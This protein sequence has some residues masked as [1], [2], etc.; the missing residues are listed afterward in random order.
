MTNKE[1]IAKLTF[2]SGVNFHV[3][4]KEACILA[5]KALEENDRLESKL[6]MYK[7][8]TE[9]FSDKNDKL[10]A[11]NEE[12]KKR[13]D[14]KET[15]LVLQETT[16]LMLASDKDM[17][18]DEANSKNKEI[19]RLK[20]ELEQSVN[21]ENFIN[22]ISKEMFSAECYNDEFNG[23]EVSNLLCLGNIADVLEDMSKWRR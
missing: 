6:K 21:V 23:Q 18:I 2:L 16:M 9:S 11:E 15:I 10:K 4:T 3:N 5:I 22:R 20:A 17:L 12:Y 14:A 8:L 1:A 7:E 13:L 19:E